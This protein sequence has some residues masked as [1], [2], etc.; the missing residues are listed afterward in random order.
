MKLGKFNL[1]KKQLGIIIAAIAVIV[2]L[3]IVIVSV[4]GKKSNNDPK[5]T[6]AS[7]TEEEEVVDTGFTSK[8][9]GEDMAEEIANNRPIAVMIENTVDAIP[10]Y[11]LNSA[12]V[13]YECPVEGGLTR[14]MA[15]FDNYYDLEQ[16]GNVRSCRPYYVYFARE[17]DAVYVHVGQ[18]IHGEVLLATGIVD[19]L[20]AL[21]G[22][23]ANITFFRT[24]EKKA[25]HNC[26]V[27]AESVLAG[28]EAE[29]YRTTYEDGY[30]GHYQ[31]ASKDAPE[32]LESGSDCAVVCPYFFNNEPYFIY[33]EETGLYD[34]YQYG[35]AQTD[36]VDGE[37]IS[38]KN[39]LFQTSATETS[40]L[41]ETQYLNIPLVG[42]GAGK[43]FTNG[44]MI[45]VTWTKDSDTS[46]THYYDASGNEIQL[47]I[48][49]TWVCLIQSEYMD[50]NEYYA[51][52][53]EFNNR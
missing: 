52:E 49:N 46:V 47:N 34:R 31:F 16:I 18:S 36:A 3:I 6:A 29:G 2:V 12:G 5:E 30:T 50:K 45:D 15:I 43:Y 22:A 32:T 17:F 19:D 9:T 35:K 7:V 1:S 53:E 42:S 20:N 25:P 10:Q 41:E 11:G 48:G 38:V 37:Q 4:T 26:Y 44:K 24:S 40:L 51:T 33:N 8:L 39:I 23:A 21:K 27:S 13:V 28:I 14:L